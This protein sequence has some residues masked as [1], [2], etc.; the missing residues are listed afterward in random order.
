M[1]A[2]MYRVTMQLSPSERVSLR[3]ANQDL[4]RILAL[5]ARLRFLNPG[6]EVTYRTD[7]RARDSGAA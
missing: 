6:F 7:E 3:V 5:A 2:S 1:E 4:A